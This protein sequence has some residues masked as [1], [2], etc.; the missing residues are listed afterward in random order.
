MG[1]PYTWFKGLISPKPTDG[2]ASLL[3]VIV[4][5]EAVTTVDVSLPARSAGWLIELIPQDVVT[6]IKAEG[7]PIE[8][9]QADLASKA[10][11]YPQKIFD[12]YE[13]HRS[14]KVWLE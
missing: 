2:R 6:K 8:D 12:L 5:R 14:V 4:E 9:I 7:I 3:R 13:P 10:S 1:C 11:L